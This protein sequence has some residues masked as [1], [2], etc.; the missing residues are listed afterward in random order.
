MATN[1]VLNNSSAPFTV[2]TGDLNVTAGNLALPATSATAGQITLNG[3]RFISGR[4]NTD[5]SVNTFVGIN[6]GGSDATASGGWN[7]GVGAYALNMIAG[8]NSN[9]AIGIYSLGSYT[10]ADSIGGNCAFGDSA[11]GGLIGGNYSGATGSYNIFFGKDAGDNLLYGDYNCLIGYY[12]AST[13][14]GVGANYNGV[15]SS[16]LLIQ[17]Q[18][19]TGESNVLRIGTTGTG[20]TQQNSCYIAGI[21]TQTVTGSAVFVTTDDQ[22]GVA[23]SSQKYK[24]DISDMSDMT[25]I[26]TNL[27]PVT[28]TYKSEKEPRPMHYGLIAEEVEKVWPEM[29]GYKDGQPDN[30]YYQFLP[31]ILLK[32]VQRLN[33]VIKDLTNRIALLE[34]KK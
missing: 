25:Q 18:G 11:G 31:P 23:T 29:V 2:T 7:T 20:V 5:T 3:I 14:H 4:I 12:G 15:E 33:G 24:D 27:R 22:L 34:A 21:Q 17:N 16:N 28:F 6:A 13:P 26:I 9:T 1:N 19:V 10:G 30:L 32:E 8:T